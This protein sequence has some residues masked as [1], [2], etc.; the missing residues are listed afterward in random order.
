MTD[1]IAMF[2]SLSVILCLTKVNLL[3]SAETKILDSESHIYIDWYF[4]VLIF[5]K[6][7]IN[8]YNLF[9]LGF[10]Q[11]TSSTVHTQA[12]LFFWTTVVFLMSKWNFFWNEM[13]F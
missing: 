2:I 13:G 1:G 5:L 4:N 12:R 10:Y 6:N 11:P 3:T 9:W 8:I 7:V